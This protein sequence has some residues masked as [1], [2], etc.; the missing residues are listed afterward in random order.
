MLPILLIILHT[1]VLSLALRFQA[2]PVRGV[3]VWA[4]LLVQKMYNDIFYDNETYASIGGISTDEMNLLEKEFLQI[5][6][7]DLMIHEPEF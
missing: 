2:V 6:D 1:Q 7:F 4:T 5:I 3:L